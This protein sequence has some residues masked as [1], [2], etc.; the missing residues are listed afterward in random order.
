MA[1]KTVKSKYKHLKPKEIPEVP[2][3]ED[4]TARFAGRSHEE[5]SKR[6]YTLELMIEVLA[7]Q[8]APLA[9]EYNFIK[10]RAIPEAAMD[11]G[12]KN[13]TYEFASD[14]DGRVTLQP[15]LWVTVL[16]KDKAFEWLEDNGHGDLI[17][18]TV[19]A[20]SLKAALKSRIQKGDGTPPPEIFRVT[21]VTYAV[22]TKA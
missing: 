9:A 5:L 10:D 15:D 16:N 6:M 20:A 19:N 8:I 4:L 11:S 21:P 13:V 1:K 18:Q 17:Q 12:I 14:Y 3:T 7:S 2:T 22:I